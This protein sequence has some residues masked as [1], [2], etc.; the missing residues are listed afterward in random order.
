MF[1]KLKHYNVCIIW[2]DV[3]IISR[4]TEWKKKCK[5]RRKV[6]GN[7]N[8][9]ISVISVAGMWSSGENVVLASVLVCDCHLYVPCPG[10][11]MFKYR[12]IWNFYGLPISFHDRVCL[13]MYLKFKTQILLSTYFL[14]Y[15]SLIN[16]I[17]FNCPI[18]H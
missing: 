5:I 8:C 18:F 7:K 9:N 15:I 17:F 12:L 11:H 16:L 4:C 10:E 3:T 2:P 6:Y 13:I 1:C 14:I